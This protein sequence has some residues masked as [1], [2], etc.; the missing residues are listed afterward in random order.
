MGENKASYMMKAGVD[1]LPEADQDVC[2]STLYSYS[3][4]CPKLLMNVLGDQGRP[5]GRKGRHGHC[6]E[7]SARKGCKL[8]LDGGRQVA[9]SSWLMLHRVATLSMISPRG[10]DD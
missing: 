2:L 1:M 6:C 10:S 8:T 5:E 9:A 7:E 4:S 3:L